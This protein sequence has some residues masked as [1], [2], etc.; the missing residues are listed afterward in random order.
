M[1]IPP[2]YC[3]SFTSVS[4]KD[5]I[6]KSS[7]NRPY[8][9]TIII[10]LLIQSI[11][12]KY[13]YPYANFLF[14]DSYCYVKEAFDNAQIDTYPIGYPM[15]LRIFS[16]ITISDTC[17]VVFQYLLL[18]AAALS[19]VFTT[20]YFFSPHKYLKR[21]LIFST[22]FNPLL[23]VIANTVSSD[24]FFL[25][26]SLIWVVL[27]IWIIYKPTKSVI[28][29]HAMVLFLLLT[30]RFNALF[31]PIISLFAFFLSKERLKIKIIG[32]LLSLLLMGFFII[33][34]R[35]KHYELSGKRQFSVFSEWQMANNGLYAYRHVPIESRKKVPDRF[36]ELDAVVREYF[37][38]AS[39]NPYNIIDNGK[40][41]YDYMF[42]RESPLWIYCL[43]KTEIKEG[44][45]DLKARA[46]VGP[47]Y[48]DYGSWLILHYPIQLI[49][50]VIWPNFKKWFIPPMEM[51]DSYNGGAIN[52]PELI[53][54][55]FK[56]KSV[57]IKSR[58][59]DPYI[60]EGIV[61]LY[62]L[63]TCIIHIV[64]LLSSMYYFVFKWKKNPS[65]LNKVVLFITFFWLVNFGFN[66]F[67]APIQM[68]HVLFP[69]QIS[70][71]FSFLLIGVF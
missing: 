70:N 61:R 22:L 17:L 14:G 20:F 52:V 71:V 63:W 29:W 39:Q 5:F 49:E 6:F 12:Y 42:M 55:W 35:E 30:V 31:Y 3:N 64:F 41:T 57:I 25:S 62:P 7:E 8:V 1:S 60:F 10:V 54:K 16:A 44:E 43:Q 40:A 47:L 18:Q 37:Y 45:S 65:N 15:F 48:N 38:Y 26:L 59:K 2:A 11:L 66:V 32:I 23:F 24:N 21:F 28:V 69:V 51:I 33:Y 46:V 50:F 27:L 19:L 9:I 13:L 56:Y 58:V 67:A 68:R 34:N 4:L 53:G 36:A